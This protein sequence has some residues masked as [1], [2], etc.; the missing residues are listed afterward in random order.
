MIDQMDK[1]GLGAQV[2]CGVPRGGVCAPAVDHADKVNAHAAAEM[3]ISSGLTDGG[4][5]QW[6]RQGCA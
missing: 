2:V 4:R 3:H 6:S 1:K 5:E